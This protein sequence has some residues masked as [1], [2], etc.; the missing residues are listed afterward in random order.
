[1]V[2]YFALGSVKA[3]VM[4]GNGGN[5][6]LTVSD[7][8]LKPVT[9]NGGAGDD[10]LRGG[11]GNDTL[12]GG[13]GADT[14]D[15]GRG[16]D[17]FNGGAGV[18]TVTYA[19]RTKSLYVNI[20]NIADDGEGFPDASVEKDNVKTDVENL[21]GG[22]A[23]DWFMGSS[24]ANTFQGFG[25]DDL[26][27]G[28]A[29]DDVLIGGDGNDAFGGEGGGGADKYYGE[30]GDDFFY[31]EGSDNVYFSGGDGDDEFYV[32]FGGTLVGGNG[33]DKFYAGGSA[34]ITI[35]AGAGN[36]IIDVCNGEVKDIVDGGTGTDQ[37]KIDK[38]SNTQLDKTTNC[39]TILV[40]VA[41]F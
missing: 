17:V 30:A 6:S 40:G 14:L 27:M 38:F 23:A 10:T 8:V 11:G 4:N 39:E 2:R 5:D 21:K 29:G 34:P 22:S 3:I 25:G 7:L 13:N 19:S 24:A 41:G 36:D 35:N 16:G 15:G 28:G 20:N 37:V 9:L 32:T 12:N 26:L 1:M 18:D 31:G 33:N